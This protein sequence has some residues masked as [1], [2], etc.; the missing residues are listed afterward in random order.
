MWIMWG[1]GWAASAMLLFLLSIQA[2]RPGGLH[3]L[4]SAHIQSIFSTLQHRM[5]QNPCRTLCHGKCEHNTETGR[6]LQEGPFPILNPTL[7]K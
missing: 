2:C 3:M 5:S 4:I 6:P 1:P 7:Y